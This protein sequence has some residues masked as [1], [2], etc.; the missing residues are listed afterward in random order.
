MIDLIISLLV[1]FWAFIIFGVIKDSIK[2]RLEKKKYL[3]ILDQNMHKVRNIDISHYQVALEELEN[4]YD[5]TFGSQKVKIK[6]I[7]GDVINICPKCGSYMRIVRWKGR[8]FLGC[9]FYP[10]CK[11]YRNYNEI[12]KI[13]I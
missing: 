3:E 8:R 11:S 7:N 4:L 2:N 9:T 13:K 1:I 10:N 5:K 6:D 12:F